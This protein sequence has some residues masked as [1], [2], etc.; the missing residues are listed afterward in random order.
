V[1]IT[2]ANYWPEEI[3]IDDGVVLEDRTG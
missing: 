2:L 1:N 3:K